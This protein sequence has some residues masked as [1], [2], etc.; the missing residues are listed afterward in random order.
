MT[1]KVGTLFPTNE[2]S[3]AVVV[4]YKNNRSVTVRFEQGNVSVVR[5]DHLRS[6]GVKNPMHRSVCGIGFTGIGKHKSKEGGK[7]SAVYTVW[8]GMMQRCYSPVYQA[9]FPTYKGCTV[10]PDWHNF[11]LFA[12]W[13]F[14][15]KYRLDGWHLDKDII[16]N[17][18]KVY[19]ADTCCFI[20]PHLNSL[21]LDCKASRGGLPQGVSRHGYRYQAS[22]ANFG[23]Q[24][25]LGLYDCP[26]AASESYKKAKLTHI[27]EVAAS[28]IGDVDQRAID[29]L[30]AWGWS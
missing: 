25:Y 14:A 8:N 20:P 9:K 28:Y 12:E 29:S 1:V 16:I 22:I 5:L 15:D 21:L 23:E 4:G 2:G 6:G 10:H 18:N 24:I 30:L 13:F 7:N 3:L 11:Q 17:G 27:K 19:S 26:F